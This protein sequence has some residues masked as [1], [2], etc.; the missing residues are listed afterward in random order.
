MS[1]PLHTCWA[2]ADDWRPGFAILGATV[3]V[4]PTSPPQSLVI[5]GADG[6]WGAHEWTV[7]PQPHHHEFPYLAWI[8]LHQSNTS[9]PSCVHTPIDKSMWQAHPDQPN[10]H[11]IDPTLLDRLTKERESVKAVLQDP[12]NTFSSDPSLSSIRYPKEA[13]IRVLAALSRLEKDFAAW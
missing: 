10:I 13:Y 4:I 1:A 11:I 8:P 12:S 5:I 7:Y 6:S 2:S 3:K 9:I